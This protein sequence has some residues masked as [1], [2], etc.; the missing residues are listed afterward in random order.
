MTASGS[1]KPRQQQ[2]ARREQ[3][4]QPAERER[5]ALRVRGRGPVGVHDADHEALEQLQVDERPQRACRERH[6]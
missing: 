5:R 6:P 2:P 1:A 3:Q 4:Q